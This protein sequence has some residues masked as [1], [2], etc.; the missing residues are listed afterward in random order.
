LGAVVAA[1]AAV[2]APDSPTA[3]A[4]HTSSVP[5]PSPRFV[6]IRPVLV[7]LL[8]PPYVVP[9][10]CALS[11]LCSLSRCHRRSCCCRQCCCCCHRCC[12]CC[13]RRAP[14]GGAVPSFICPRS[15]LRSSVL[16]LALTFVLL[17]SLTFVLHPCSR[18]RSTV[19]TL[20]AFVLSL[21]SQF[22]VHPLSVVP[23]QAL[24]PL[25]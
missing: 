17:S 13:C 7:I 10:W 24:G 1:A 20:A 2:A 23:V 9:C 16:A 6:R 4:A 5:L 11:A 12:C 3:A 15:C 19:V 25:D 21:S 14:G 22:A 8:P 18:P